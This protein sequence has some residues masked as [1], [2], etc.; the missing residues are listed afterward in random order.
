MVLLAQR[1][2][3]IFMHYFFEVSLFWLISFDYILKIVGIYCIHL[4]NPE[5]K[6]SKSSC[7]QGFFKCFFNSNVP[8]GEGRL[9]FKKVRSYAIR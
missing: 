4:K 9:F 5:I 7:F 8:D 3:M 6:T 2:F 1:G